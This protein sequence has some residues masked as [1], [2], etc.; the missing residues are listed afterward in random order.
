MKTIVKMFVLLIS[1]ITI[2]V[3]AQRVVTS[4]PRVEVEVPKEQIIIR[5]GQTTQQTVVIP[6]ATNNPAVSVTT[7]TNYYGQARVVNIITVYQA[8]PQ[9]PIIVQVQPPVIAPAPQV[10]VPQVAPQLYCPPP[11]P[12]HHQPVI[13]PV[14]Y[15]PPR[16][17]PCPPPIQQHYRGPELITGAWDFSNPRYYDHRVYYGYRR[18]HPGHW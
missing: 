16:L 7:Q 5:P 2:S 3:E 14:Y 13:E 11:A 10:Y 9:E 12:V 1:F 17:P 8:P 4:T 18:S 15:L 6:A